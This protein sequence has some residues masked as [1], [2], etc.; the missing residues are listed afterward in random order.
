MNFIFRHLA[1]LSREHLRK[2]FLT[3]QTLVRFS[4]VTPEKYCHRTRSKCKNNL[5]FTDTTEK[6]TKV[7]HLPLKVVPWTDPRSGCCW[8]NTSTNELSVISGHPIIYKLNLFETK[9]KLSDQLPL[10]LCIQICQWA[11]LRNK[12]KV[13]TD[14]ER[15]TSLCIVGGNGVGTGDEGNRFVTSIKL[16][17]S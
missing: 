11:G 14:L 15:Q 16:I 10:E 3:K 6:R 7:M 12:L 13:W 8:P 17:Y 5:L 9:T 2:I 4:S 1:D